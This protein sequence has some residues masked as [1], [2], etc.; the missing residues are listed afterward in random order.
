M[1]SSQPT[2]FSFF[3]KNK[4]DKS[5]D[6]KIKQLLKPQSAQSTNKPT[7]TQQSQPSKPKKSKK[8]QTF[9]SEDNL[10]I[11]FGGTV[12]GRTFK[13]ILDDHEEHKS[14][15][16]WLKFKYQTA[17]DIN[18]AARAHNYFSKNLSDW[19]KIEPYSEA[20]DLPVN[21]DKH[22]DSDD[23][24]VINFGNKVN[25]MSFKQVLE[26]HK[27][28]ENWLRWLKYRSHDT[29]LNYK[30]A[31]H[32]RKYFKRNLKEVWDKLPKWDEDK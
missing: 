26:N 30:L 32:A 16:R 15:L 17:R 14:W 20:E 4:T 10:V 31:T 24:V 23:D 5:Q 25:G 9:P 6:N 21:E 18:L 22:Y 11:T 7:Q 28:C 19:D 29:K 12:K 13:Q 8:Y 27:K 3:S 1:T 2:L